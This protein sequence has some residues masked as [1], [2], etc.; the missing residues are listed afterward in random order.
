MGRVTARNFAFSGWRHWQIRVRGEKGPDQ[1]GGG[2]RRS[3][4]GELDENG[5][6]NAMMRDGSGR[7]AVQV[8]VGGRLV[9]AEND[10]WDESFH[11]EGGESATAAGLAGVSRECVSRGHVI[12]VEWVLDVGDAVDGKGIFRGKNSSP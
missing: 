9:L 10:A 1:G 6:G 7:F 4:Q 8:E 11:A 12:L 3:I 5:P 2:G